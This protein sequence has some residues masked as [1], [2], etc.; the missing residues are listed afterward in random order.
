[1]KITFISDTHGHEPKLP[2]GDILVHTGD[3][4]KHGYRSEVI[5]QLN[6]LH[7]QLD[8]YKHIVIIPGNHDFWAERHPEE[9]KEASL[10]AGITALIHEGIEIEGINFWGSPATPTFHN[11]AFNYD[12]PEIEKIWDKIPSNTDILIT[13]GPPHGVRDLTFFQNNA[14]CPLLLEK[15]REI[16]PRIHAFGHIHEAAGIAQNSFTLFVN[17][18]TEVIC[19]DYQADVIEYEVL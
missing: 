10:S 9:F 8:K 3:L 12:M 18:A 4:T 1:M 2:G 5:K 19:V 11:W 6:Y 14:G 17:S 7:E 16:K 15:V 13:H